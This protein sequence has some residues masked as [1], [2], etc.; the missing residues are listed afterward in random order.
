MGLDTVPQEHL[1]DDEVE[2]ALSKAG[3]ALELFREAGNKASGFLTDGQGLLQVD[4]PFEKLAWIHIP[5]ILFNL[6]S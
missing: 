4:L 5:M 2:E 6:F 3:Q 1:Q